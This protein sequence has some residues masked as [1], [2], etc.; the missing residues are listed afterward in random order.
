MALAFAEPNTSSRPTEQEPAAWRPVLTIAAGVVG[1]S[2]AVAPRY[3]YHRDELYFLRAGHEPAWGYPDQPPLV[4]L[5][6]RAMD[7][8]AP[9]SLLAPF[10]ADRDLRALGAVSSAPFR[11]KVS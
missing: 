7:A 11:A 4:P 5:L 1:L 10:E 6:A 2:L 9:G 8:I 3:G